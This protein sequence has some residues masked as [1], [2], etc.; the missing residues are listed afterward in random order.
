V[1]GRRQWPTDRQAQA[2]SS[3]RK[4]GESNSNRARLA[5]HGTHCDCC[6]ADAWAMLLGGSFDW[7]RRRPIFGQRRLNEFWGPSR[8]WTGW[9][10]CATERRIR[11][12]VMEERTSGS[13]NSFIDLRIA[14][15]QH[16]CH[17]VWVLCNF[18]FRTPDAYADS[19]PPCS[20]GR[21]VAHVP[22]GCFRRWHGE[23]RPNRCHFRRGVAFCNSER[24]QIRSGVVAR[25][26]CRYPAAR[27]LV[28]A[29][30]VS[31]LPIPNPGRRLRGLRV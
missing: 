20:V 22:V 26:R 3:E 27:P 29:G 19:G 30:R 25:R 7:G 1:R 12:L 14:E 2:K 4:A 23:N 10:D 17:P 6:A 5:S 31:G 21:N 18:L 9:R 15:G 28:L 11:F 24:Y 8:R 13:R 16:P